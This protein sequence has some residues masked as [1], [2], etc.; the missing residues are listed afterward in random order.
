MAIALR[1]SAY[2]PKQT[3]NLISIGGS[4]GC[5]FS[6][7]ARSQSDGENRAVV[8]QPLPR[9]NRT[10]RWAL[11]LLSDSVWCPLPH[12]STPDQQDDYCS[13]DSAD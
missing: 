4:V 5:H 8:A 12:N 13:D 11:G 7:G 1:M 9:Y 2:D 3:L 10:R 6:L